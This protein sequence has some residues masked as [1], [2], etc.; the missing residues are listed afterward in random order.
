MIALADIIDRITVLVGK[1]LACLMLPL[2]LLVFA[3]AILRYVFGLGHV[4]LFEAVG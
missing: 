3:N 1:V 4:W 2:V